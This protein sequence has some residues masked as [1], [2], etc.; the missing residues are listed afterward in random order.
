MMGNSVVS[1]D[2]MRKL[3]PDKFT[4]EDAIFGHIKPGDRILI[5][6]AC[7]EPQYL[8][9]A[10][11]EYV[12]AHPTAFFD[13]E[14]MQVWTLGIAPYADEK[15]KDSF[16]LNSFF[17]GDSIRTAI[18]K[19]D[20][21]YTP[22]FLSVVPD[23]FSQKIISLDVVLVQ[24]TPPND[25]GNMSL[26]ISV[27]ITK[28]AI[29][30]ASLVIAQANSNMPYVHGDGLINI[31]DLDFVMP[32]DEPL[33]EYEDIVP[34]DIAQR[35]GHYVARIVDDGS[36][37]QVGYGSIP[38]AI[39]PSLSCKRHLGV[40]T[41]LFSEGIAELMKIGVI[42][43]TKKSVDQDKAVATFCMGTKATYDFL[44]DNPSVEFR[45]IDYTNDILII[46][47]Q[48][49][50]T[51]INSALEIDLTG[52]ATAESLGRTFY[53]GIGGQADFMRGAALAEGGKTILAMPSTARDGQLSRIVPFLAKGT[54][55]TLGRG[56]VRY[57]VTEYGIAYLHGR[58]IRERAMSL[59]AI[60][61]PKFRPWLIE[62][63][64]KAHLIYAD[65]AILSY[66]YPNY[67]ETYRTTKAGL[68][69]LLRPVK[70][71][72][73]P[74]LKDFF[75][76]LSNASMY[77]RFASARRDM[78]HRRLQDFVAADYNERM[79]ILA[80]TGSE[81]REHIVGIV[82]YILNKGSQTA[83]LALVVRDEFQ[84]KGI[85][86][87]LQSYITDLAKRR[88]LHGF[89]AEVLEENKPALRLLEKTGFSIANIGE[90]GVYELMLPL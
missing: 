32:H 1:W 16:R 23:L 22:V 62:M 26:G 79:I 52:Q 9:R 77:M 83:E 57:V 70:I 36:T 34:A 15:F 90:C 54:G 44:Q 27:D 14:L 10:L 12:N 38:N 88:G 51:A 20:A 63:A 7:G 43:N 17:A 49:H 53:S 37:I 71:S 6:T 28:A 61:H 30:N 2:C 78:P 48:R 72:D 69:I 25:E 45:T 21:D 66:E 13:A 18:N 8:V 35:I 87:E 86:S 11:T 65:Q 80:V 58:N 82:Q 74:L 75:Y 5:G 56:D 64:K 50:M 29:E 41:E 73:E 24:T 40:H 19:A 60:A 55:V 47:N 4:S 67:L 31:E 39:L 59:I 85:G 3:W 46:A 89:T 68:K 33:L 81:E 76:S 84:G 42:D